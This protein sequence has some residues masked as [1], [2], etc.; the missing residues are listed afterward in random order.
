M[1]PPNSSEHECVE[2]PRRVGAQAILTLRAPRHREPITLH[3][4]PEGALTVGRDPHADVVLTEAGIARE[5]ALLTLEHDSVRVRPVE[6]APVAINGARVTAPT[7]LADGDWLVLGGATFAVGLRI[8]PPLLAGAAPVRV[9]GPQASS[10]PREIAIG[11]LPECEIR[12]DSPVVSRHHARIVNEDG[13]FWI[14]DLN[15]TNGTFL[16]G[17]LVV[18]RVPLEAGAHLEV[19]TFAFE[20]DGLT[21]RELERSGTIRV[22]SRGVAHEVRD[23]ASGKTRRILD[24]IDLAIE[25]GEFVAIVGSSGS[26][27]STLLDALSGRRPPSHGSV[28]YNGSGLTDGFELFRSSIGYVPQQDIVHRRIPIRRALEY[29]A[30]LRLP[31]DTSDAEVEARIS[32]VLDDVDLSTKG[33]QII[34]TPSPLSGGQLKRVNLAVELVSQPGILF[35]D[36]ATSGL[37][38]GTEGRMMRLFAELA[39][40]RRTVVCVT[41]SLEHIARCDLIALLHNGRMVYFGPPRG[42]L[43][44]F[45]VDRL[46]DVYDLLDTARSDFWVERFCGSHFHGEF[47][48]DRLAPHDATHPGGSPAPHRTRP[49]AREPSAILLRS[50]TLTRRYL[51]LLVADRRNLAILLAQAPLIGLVVGGVFDPGQTLGERGRAEP[52]VAF[53][54]V[55]AMIWFGCLNS[56]REIVKELPIYLRERAVGLGVTEYI[57]SKLIP[58]AALCALQ[59]VMLLGVTRACITLSGDFLAQLAALLTVGLSATAMGLMVSALVRSSDKAIASVP[60]LLVPQVILSG[61]IVPL[62]GWSETLAK[63]SMISFWGFDVMKGRLGTDLFA[64]LV[65]MGPPLLE[66]VVSAD[67]A[68]WILASFFGVFVS[69]TVL[70]LRLRGARP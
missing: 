2:P 12:I 56:A 37:D 44:H 13:R 55:I 68:T 52:Q 25:P 46:A 60:I 61:A 16:N 65:P 15:S 63:A 23:R 40:T 1:H 35:L 26:G 59:A 54:L 20:F 53:L 5:H 10:A 36:E 57:T 31:P 33:G 62:S 49:R 6:E 43:E 3:L 42:A 47:V 66:T 64:P 8:D 70:A 7:R 69:L 41:H 38:A 28:L 58:L 30:R 21:L 18:G 48:R 24:G 32:Q 4:L 14:E 50:K 19:A 67:T 17:R 45:S 29:T 9:P 51:D 11:R 39:K 27:K 22:E 34:D